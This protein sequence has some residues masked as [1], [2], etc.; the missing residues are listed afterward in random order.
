[1][2]RVRRSGVGTGT[3]NVETGIEIALKEDNAGI[4]N[5]KTGIQ[6][7]ETDTEISPVKFLNTLSDTERRIV[8]FI[9]EDPG[10][11]QNQI[12]RKMEM[13]KSG[14]RYAMD[15]LKIEEFLNV[16]GLPKGE[17]GLLI[18]FK[19]CALSCRPCRQKEWWENED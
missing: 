1:V 8:E 9:K 5:L 7:K 15:R 3:E 16:R 10:I 13:S 11:T 18:C 19:I 6:I 14:I 12:A 2:Q 17:G 4:V